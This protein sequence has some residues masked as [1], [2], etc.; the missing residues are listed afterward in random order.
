MPDPSQNPR[1]WRGTASSGAGSAKGMKPKRQRIFTVLAAML[2]LAGTIVGLLVLL[3]PVPEPYLVPLWVAE[4]SFPQVPVNFLAEP[5]RRALLEGNYFRQK[6]E[7]A[8]A[9]QQKNQLLQELDR[10]AE[11][12]ESDAVVV[13]LCAFARTA[14]Q[15]QVLI[16]PG[17]VKP[18]DMQTFL[19][20]R[21]VLQ[22]LHRNPAKHKLLILDIMR[23][24]ADPRLGILADNVA[25]RV[26]DELKAVEDPQ[27]LVLCSCSAGQVSLT[28]EAM[29]RSVFGYY[30]EEGLRGRADGLNPDGKRDGHISVRELAEYVKVRV[31][32]WAKQNR[33]TRQTP[34]LLP[35]DSKEDFQLV[36]LEHGEPQPHLEPAVIEDYPDWL[37]AGWGIRDQAR[38]DAAFQWSPRAFR[39]LEAHLLRAEQEWRGGTEP[40]RVKKHL[41]DQL[42]QIQKLFQEARAIVKVEPRS[43]AL[44]ESWG[45]KPDPAVAEAVK[46]LLNKFD[47]VPT[48]KPKEAEDAQNKLIKSYLEK[49]KVK[50]FDLARAV[51]DRA[52]A[53]RSPSSDK[54]RFLAKLLQARQPQ[55]RY[56]E[57]LFLDRYYPKTSE[58]AKDSEGLP[59]ALV[60]KSLDVVDKGEK[61]ASQEKALPWIR[62]LLDEA[63]QDRHNAE[64]L[65]A[66]PK[67]GSLLQADQS[68]KNASD[69]YVDVLAIE[70]TILAS[71][72]ALDEAMIVLPAYVPYLIR[73]PRQEETWL[74]ATQAAQ[75]LAE[76]LVPPPADAP[77]SK[78]NLQRKIDELAKVSEDLQERLKILSRPFGKEEMQKL[79]KK[80]E[81]RDAVP[82]DW[83]ELDA[84]M[85]TPF[86]AAE[87]R[88]ALWIAARDLSGRL[89]GETIKLDEE[90]DQS[91]QPPK[92]LTDF[93]AEGE[94]WQR[95]ADR[96]A[97]YSIALLKMAGFAASEIQR[98]EDARSRVAADQADPAA[99]ETLA[100]S[101][102]VAWAE[103][104]PGQLQEERSVFV[105]DRLG[106]LI[107]P[108]ES[109]SFLDNA[110]TNPSLQAR[111]KELTA[112]WTWLADHYQYENRDLDRS[113]F[114]DKAAR[115]YGQVS[116]PFPEV[117]LQFTDDVTT[118]NVTPKPSASVTL[119]LQLVGRP[120]EKPQVDLTVPADDEW[121]QVIPP[122]DL[123]GRLEELIERGSC[124]VPLRVELK[125]GNQKAP[126]AGPPK[127]FLVQASL[128]GRTFHHKVAAAPVVKPEIVLSDNPKGTGPS[129]GV[130]SLRP[131]KSRTKYYLFVRNPTD[132]THNL[133]VQLFAP[134]VPEVAPVEVKLLKPAELRPV[135]FGKSDPPADKDL[136]QLQGPLEVRLF[137][138]DAGTE[139]EK[140]EFPVKIASPREY[141]EVTDILWYP[142]S[143][144]DDGKNRLEVKIQPRR[145]IPKPG[146]EVML[147]LPADRITGFKS[148]KD[149]IFKVT[150]LDKPEVLYAV[151]VQL[152]E[153]TQE[154]GLVYLTVDGCERAFVFKTTFRRTGDPT[155]PQEVEQTSIRLGADKYSRPDP[156]FPVTVEVDNPP[157]SAQLELSLG[158]VTGKVFEAVRPIERRPARQQWL[159]FSQQSADGA[160]LFEAFFRD[161]KVEL[162]TT[163]IVGKYELRARLVD[164]GGE[165]ILS[166]T[167]LEVVLDDS[168]PVNLRF[169][170]TESDGKEV[171]V[172]AE[173]EDPE[174][175][176]REVRFYVGK[177]E[178]PD[179][180]KPP[181]KV[182]PI[183]GIQT[184]DKTGWF[185][186]FPNKMVEFDVTVEFINN[187]GQKKLA[188]TQ[189]SAIAAGPAKPGVIQGVVVNA[190][191]IGQVGSA[192]SLLDDKGKVKEQ[193][194]TNGDAE[195]QFDKVEPGE[196]TVSSEKKEKKVKV[197]S[198]KTVTVKIVTP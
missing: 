132:K 75:H 20:L 46:D 66:A 95:L 142:S 72:R 23:P 164:A 114:Y 61:A 155:S 93:V 194:K 111:S 152:E 47:E 106:R 174:S 115:E 167:P 136:P 181:D 121:L 147:V 81:R 6:S 131:G 107:P 2:A 143:K 11:R 33:D 169:S 57:T 124:T 32:R 191:G 85:S 141:V 104:L 163:N 175:G 177:P 195:F 116:Q 198:G 90:E 190:A 89:H 70:K 157:E 58:A 159:G 45:H 8:F 151:N 128:N 1:G 148:K 178:G 196:Y 78:A 154:N 187:A 12:R 96:R 185:A 193:T 184:L 30:L 18:D 39:Q 56:V 88:A 109:S 179:G 68:L 60:R 62:G 25:S 9:R 7:S 10:L 101:L 82:T 102:R 35:A 130:L 117:F 49:N 189:V 135:V 125:T 22:A 92:T 84:I 51:F 74:A 126:T 16:L 67:F 133:S 112:L 171:T 91:H 94:R 153:N 13:Y 29:G 145:P 79:I 71:Q 197:E 186:K 119:G 41:E 138:V 26:A 108:F 87:D 43:L 80:S 99:A 55:P 83:L 183:V 40:S 44:A 97:C 192:V 127:G 144:K 98:L 146:C 160:L 134:G 52:V 4:Y 69:K 86:P 166:A 162:D 158:K 21:N 14:S 65:L 123:R 173:G 48:D 15:G 28:S 118:A 63:A 188:T 176:I 170:K 110:T 64:I 165:E 172:T 182:K 103:Q 180:D 77:L 100:S 42:D 156:K 140:R 105:Q 17:D 150:L 73:T 168:P 129:L 139:L 76:I 120:K 36:A 149:G 5:D 31:D 113:D 54:I 50:E 59:V 3:R 19:P 122:P 24:L 53:D 161:W 27:R 34:I 37:Q 38:K 137:D